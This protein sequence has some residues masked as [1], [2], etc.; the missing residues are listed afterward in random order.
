MS[1]ITDLARQLGMALRDDQRF[2]D[3]EE[4]RNVFD[5]DLELQKI[6]GEYEANKQILQAEY[7]KEEKDQG[8]IRSVSE[9]MKELYKIIVANPHMEELNRVQEE[10]EKLVN[11]VNSIISFFLNG[12][13][14]GGCSEDKC[15][16]C[17][18]HCHH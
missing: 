13:Q 14:A 4:A 15:A 2:K 6:I 10:M 8:V 11:E 18:G 16:S 3:V 5:S 17:G 9:R 12:E 7:Q 1:N